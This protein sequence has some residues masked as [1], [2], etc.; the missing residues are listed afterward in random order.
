MRYSALAK[1]FRNLSLLVLGSLVGSLAFAQASGNY[2]SKPVTLVV[3][4]PPG[5]GA[6]A[7]ARPLLTGTP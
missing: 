1:N 4:Y 5:G 2:P 6:D 3:T 7:M